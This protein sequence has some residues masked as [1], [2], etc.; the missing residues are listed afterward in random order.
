MNE[1]QSGKTET[2]WDYPMNRILLPVISTLAAL[3]LASAAQASD[4][5]RAMKGHLPLP[6][7]AKSATARATPAACHPDPGKGRIC[8]HVALKAEE[9]REEA[10]AFADAGAAANPVSAQ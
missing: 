7:N 2:C 3:G 6:D 9:T 5:L 10:R 4:S 1:P 8:R